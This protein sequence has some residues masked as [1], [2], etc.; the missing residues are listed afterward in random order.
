MTEAV[1]RTLV[2]GV[3][4]AALCAVAPPAQADVRAAPDAGAAAQQLVERYA[5][6]VVVRRHDTPCG[7]DGEP[8]VPMTVDALL[9]NPEVALRQVGNGDQ[10][11]TW[12][13]TARDL[14][15]GGEGVYLD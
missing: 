6:V 14:Y 9:D 10:V 4:L 3:A 5:P 13:P 7:T 1:T 12:A 8:Y 2:V 11:M 15:S